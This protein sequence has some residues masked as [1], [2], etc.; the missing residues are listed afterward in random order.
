[1]SAEFDVDSSIIPYHLTANKGDIKQTFEMYEG[2]LTCWIYN[3]ED[4]SL[5]VVKAGST[6]YTDGES[7]SSLPFEGAS[8]VDD[9]S[10][11]TLHAYSL[12]ERKKAFKYES[13][14]EI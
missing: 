2:L 3:I 14:Y 9:G 12:H 8:D 5:Q 7:F 1:V 6:L 10:V 13:P 4:N 11:L